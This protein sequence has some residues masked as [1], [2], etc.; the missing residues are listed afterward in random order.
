MLNSNATHTRHNHGGDIPTV[1]GARLRLG[2]ARREAAWRHALV[3]V[4]PDAEARA[5][6]GAGLVVPAPKAGGSDVMWHD[7]MWV[8]PTQ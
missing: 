4:R 7:V 5:T 8:L 6:L 3:V 1:A 2:E